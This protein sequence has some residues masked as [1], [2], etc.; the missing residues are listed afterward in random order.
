MS[1]PKP[2]PS[3]PASLDNTLASNRPSPR[4]AVAPVGAEPARVQPI[5]KASH[6]PTKAP[7]PQGLGM[8]SARCEPPW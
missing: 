7:M 1:S 3:F 2:R 6:L 4:G 5:Q 8:D